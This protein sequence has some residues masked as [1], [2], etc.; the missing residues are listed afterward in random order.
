MKDISKEIEYRG[1]TY[2]IVFNLNVM[3]LIQ[4]RGMGRGHEPR[5]R[6]RAAG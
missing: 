5:G 4:G 3:Q 2:K 6:Q 1:K